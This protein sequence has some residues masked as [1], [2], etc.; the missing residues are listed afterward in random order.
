MEKSTKNRLSLKTKDWIGAQHL[1]TAAFLLVFV[2][3]IVWMIF[4]L[5]SNTLTNLASRGMQTGFDFLF[6][7]A[8]FGIDFT[9]IP[10]DPGTS[11][12]LRVFLVGI[13]NTLFLSLLAIVGSTILAFIVGISRLS[14][15]WL[16]A[17]LASVYVELIRNTP[18]LVQIV[19]WHAVIFHALPMVK[20]SV[21]VFDLGLIFLNNRGLYVPTPVTSYFFSLSLTGFA[22]AVSA[23]LAL[24]FWARRRQAQS[25]KS[26]PIVWAS[27]AIFPLFVFL[28]PLL[29]GANL[30]WSLPVLGQ[31]NYEGGA[32]LPPAFVI[33]LVGLTI[34]HS[35]HKAETIRAGIQSVPQGQLDA[36][37]ALGLRRRQMMTLVLIPQALRA[38]IPS[39]INGWLTVTRNASLGI[40]IGYPELVGLFMQT[41][42]NQFGHAIEIVAMVMGFYGV[43]SLAISGLLNLYNKHV[44]MID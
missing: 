32:R 21:D 6:H 42:L 41:S 38:I 2:G 36:A 19:F 16:V 22:V 26:F 31:Y 33:V 9:L 35:A 43:L 17:V 25:G 20:Q 44:A 10:Y 27:I 14:S 18:I 24:R 3:A 29:A 37:R 15:N 4:F 40:A 34:Y 1:H 39:L 23:I 12:Y 8:G 5:I 7:T 28:V 11:S 13:V 30:E